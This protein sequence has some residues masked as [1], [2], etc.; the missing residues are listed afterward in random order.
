MSVANFWGAVHFAAF[1]S[2]VNQAREKPKGCVKERH[3][4]LSVK[5]TI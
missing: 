4:T 3:G 1:L 2:F 5:A